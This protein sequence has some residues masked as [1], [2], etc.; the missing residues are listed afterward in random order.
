MM[1]P[2]Q[3]E[4]GIIVPDPNFVKG[5][6]AL[7]DKHKALLETAMQDARLLVQKDPQLTSERGQAARICM[8][9]FE[10]D[11]GIALMKAG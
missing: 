3:G 8:Y 5:V 7:C 11:Y 1:E 10:Q 6:R 4:G 9:L 2:M